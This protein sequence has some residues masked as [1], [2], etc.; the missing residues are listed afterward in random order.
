MAS[1]TRI[2]SAVRRAVDGGADMSGDSWRRWMAR[3]RCRWAW[4]DT[5]RDSYVMQDMERGR[6]MGWRPASRIVR[7]WF[8]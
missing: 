8:G 4:A 5:T 6:A 2:T 1:V 7:R 3:T